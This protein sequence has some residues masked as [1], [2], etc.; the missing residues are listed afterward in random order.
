MYCVSR[1][2]LLLS[3]TAH[4]TKAFTFNNSVH[5][6]NKKDVIQQQSNCK[7]LN[8]L[9]RLDSVVVNNFSHSLSALDNT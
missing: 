8:K 9:M 4:I 7:T 2:V 5:P 6:C 1:V 3:F